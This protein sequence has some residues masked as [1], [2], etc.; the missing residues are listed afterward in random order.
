MKKP[1]VVS[2]N[3]SKGGI[4]KI[5][6]DSVNIIEKGLV[7]DEHNHE[8]HYRLAQAVCIQDIERLN[9]LSK[10][11]YPLN[12]GTAGE[13]LTVEGLNVNAL[14]IGTI[15]EFSG[16][17][18]LE[19]TRTRPTCYVMDQIHPS[20]KED[21]TGCHGMYARVLKEGLLTTGEIIGVTEPFSNKPVDP[22]VY[23]HTGAIFCGGKS[24]RM[25]KPKAS[26]IL[27]SGLTA[28]EHVYRVLKQFCK[29]VVLVG[30]AEGAPD[31][32]R[33]LKRIQ[34]NHQ[35]L[36]PMGALEALLS[37]GL[38][39]EYLISPC[40]LPKAIPEIF[41]LLVKSETNL[42]V[43]ISNKGYQEPLLGR[44]PSP[45]LPYVQDHII[46]RQLAMKDLLKE[47]SASSIDIPEEYLFSLS[48]MN[49]P[50]DLT[51]IIV[52]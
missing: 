38:D 42:P 40:D 33:H 3:I 17:V 2:I 12:P 51:E 37:S 49:S 14:P 39:S 9:E 23:Q 31:S 32:L 1:H 44:Y 50:E 7:G 8:K 28:I 43:V 52:N 21:A 22:M 10:K 36:G 19:I 27:P 47:V 11:G 6:I 4:P 41:S 29:E 48:N 24:S 15:L 25:G 45:L 16:G 5:P 18:V 30:H 46:R 20:L 35:G 34:D 13:N 26:I